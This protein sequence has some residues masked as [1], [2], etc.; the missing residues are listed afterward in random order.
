[1]SAFFFKNQ[2]IIK[3]NRQSL[4][5]IKE[6]AAR[7][8]LRRSRYCLHHNTTDTVQEMV[9]A[10]CR[11]SVVP[12]HRHKNKSESFH[13]IEG[14]VELI[15]FTDQAEIIDRFEMGPIDSGLPFV[16][17]LASEKWH[18]VRPL[19]EMVVIH[20]T[21]SGPFI[22]EESETLDIDYTTL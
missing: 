14:R 21:I 18:M 7:A 9:I 1:M 6:E 13:I 15:F 4:D 19:T 2:D 5:K 3:I 10:F 16:Y 12:V 22:K 20:E 17:R 8:P 11:D